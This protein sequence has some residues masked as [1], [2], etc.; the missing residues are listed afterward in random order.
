MTSDSESEYEQQVKA[1]KQ[2]VQ[3]KWTTEHEDQ[4]EQI[5]MRNFFDFNASAREFSKVINSNPTDTKWYQIDAKSLQLR[6]T[7]IEIRKYR[8]GANQSQPHEEDADPLPPLEEFKERQPEPKGNQNEDE[9]E[10]VET[11]EATQ[12][13][14]VTSYYTNLE[15]LD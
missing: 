11:E 5:L 4:L 14:G 13:S 1:T 8:L 10:E 9:G 3:F 15:E 2:M 7:D 6:W 12:D